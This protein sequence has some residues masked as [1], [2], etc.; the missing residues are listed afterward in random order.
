[1]ERQQEIERQCASILSIEMPRTL[2]VQGRQGQ[3]D[4]LRGVQTYKK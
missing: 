1:L 2:L 4:N 3:V